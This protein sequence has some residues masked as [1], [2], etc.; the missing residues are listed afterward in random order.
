MASRNSGVFL[1]NFMQGFSFVDE[2]KRQKKADQR[3]TVRLDEERAERSFQRRRQQRTDRRVSTLF[4][5]QQ[6]D[7]AS[8]LEDKANAEEGDQFA[9]QNPDA[10]IEELS[11]FPHSPEARAAI[12]RQNL[13]GRKVSAART[14]NDLRQRNVAPSATAPGDSV[15]PIVDPASAEAAGEGAGFGF[16]RAPSAGRAGA[17]VISEEEFNLGSEA[18]QSKGFFGKIGDVV[19]G[20]IVQTGRALGDIGVAA[21]GGPGSRAGGQNVGEEFSGEITVPGEFTTT[22]EFAQM[23]EAGSSEAE[24]QAADAKNDEIRTR[25]ESANPSAFGR[26]A[27]IL[28]A[29]DVTRREAIAAENDAVK[30]VQDFLDPNT[31]AESQIGQM[32]VEDPKAA[33]ARYL[34]IEAT[35]RGTNPALAQK[36]TAAMEPTFNA[37]QIQLSTELQQS[38]VGTPE[39]RQ[40]AAKQKKLNETRTQLAYTQPPVARQAG[41]NSS[42]LKIGDSE[43]ADDFMSAAYNPDRPAPTAVP[44][45][46]VN[47]AAAIAG[48]I[49]PGK[50]LNNVQLEA[51]ITGL[52]AGWIDKPTFSSVLQTG[53]W[54][55]GKNPNEIRKTIKVG[56]TMWAQTEAGRMFILT[57]PVGDRKVAAGETREFG[58]DQMKWVAE[59]GRM[60]GVPEGRIGELQGMMLQNAGYVRKHY[61]MNSPES[62]MVASQ[63]FS[64]SMILNAADHKRMS[65]D[66]WYRFTNPKNAFTANE[67]FHNEDLRKRLAER[68]EVQ[69]VPVPPIG[70]TSNYDIEP[71]K[72]AV[73]EGT[74]GQKLQQDHKNGVMSDADY[75]YAWA[76]INMT[77]EQMA[78]ANANQQGE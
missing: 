2:I 53:Q 19:G 7:R 56:E 58:E 67:I 71:F 38:T 4:G 23:R 64:Q 24:I 13:T 66:G 5:Q 59:G 34:E 70:N 35:V 11:Q 72:A 26:Q 62:M 77:P 68:Y 1:Q 57:D 49:A 45:G 65:E 54:P 22:D 50:R 12:K 69:L 76:A 30:T 39:Y 42:G 48:R 60:A 43:R 36:M 20:Q 52:E 44:S 28:N 3:L 14:L 73:D 41:I 51:L 15:A 32:A 37:A 74:H 9:L 63:I 31:T 27:S 18:F 8:D 21:R 16:D 78:A 25:Y 46:R 33:I 17:H 29:S 55:P 40:T 6:E 47:S 10:S 61:S 75:F